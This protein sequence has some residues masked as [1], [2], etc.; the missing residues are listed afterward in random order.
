MSRNLLM[1]LAGLAV[2]VVTLF[3]SWRFGV[4]FFLLPLFFFWPWGGGERGGEDTA[5]A[6][7]T[8]GEESHDNK[9]GPVE[10]SA[11]GRL[12]GE[13]DEPGGRPPAGRGLDGEGI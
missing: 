10:E 7:G 12:G 2:A 13:K 4:V 1:L 5:E 9:P 6:G 11:G 3:V 8:G